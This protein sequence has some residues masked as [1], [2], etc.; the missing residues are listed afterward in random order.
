[1]RNHNSISQNLIEWTGLKQN[2][3]GQ[4]FRTNE[5]K[6]ITSHVFGKFEGA[7]LLIKG[8]NDPSCESNQENSSSLI[9]KDEF[10]AP[11][12]ISSLA[13]INSFACLPEWIWPEVEN[14]SDKTD[15]TIVLSLKK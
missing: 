5:F 3:T 13:E 10:G 12:S 2:M 15:L 4:P 8:S 14:A 6:Q 7:T 1:M 11:L 9:L